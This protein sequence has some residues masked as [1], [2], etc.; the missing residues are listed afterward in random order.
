MTNATIIE[1]IYTIQTINDETAKTMPSSVINS[2]INA[3]LQAAEIVGLAG[4]LE[5]VDE[6]N[7]TPILDTT[8]TDD[9]WNN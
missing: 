8:D 4:A 7:T 9:S 2:I 6:I 3:A 1:T 5:G